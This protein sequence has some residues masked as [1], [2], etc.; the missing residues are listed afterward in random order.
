M[1]DME[2]RRTTVILS[3]EEDRMLREASRKTGVSQSELIRRGI[4]AVASGYVRRA[5]PRTGWLTLSKSEEA[6]IL[7]DGFGDPDAGR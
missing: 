7:A 2:N 1:E 5:K 4:R 3:A 6:E